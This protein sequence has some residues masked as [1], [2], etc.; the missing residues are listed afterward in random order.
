VDKD[1][2]SVTRSVAIWERLFEQAGVIIVKQRW[3]RG[4]PTSLFP[5]KMW[6][7]K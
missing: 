3:Q 7:L 6:M 1:D 2:C 5:V 4:F